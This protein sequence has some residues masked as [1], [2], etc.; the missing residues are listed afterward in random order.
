M[1][2]MAGIP[3]IY[4]HSLFGSRNDLIGVE[5]TGRLRSINRQKIRADELAQKLSDPISTASQVFRA[6]CQLLRA[7]RHHP[8]FNPYAPKRVLDLHPGIFALL[9]TDLDGLRRMICLHEVA[10]RATRLN[11]GIRESATIQA[12]DILTT[13]EL[14]LSACELD[15]YQVRWIAI[16]E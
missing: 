1:L 3:G 16:D 5:A 14:D 13:E 11:V 12:I 4:F 15:P 8:A 10:G 2:S 7:R 6:Y 9:R